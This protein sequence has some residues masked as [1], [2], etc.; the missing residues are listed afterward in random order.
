[1]NII[2]KSIK[3]K[4]P[5]LWFQT[6]TTLWLPLSNKL[7]FSVINRKTQCVHIIK[8]VFTFSLSTKDITNIIKLGTTLAISLR[9]FF[10]YYFCFVPIILL[11]IDK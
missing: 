10:P 9:R 8:D 6:F 3:I 1:M 4:L 11:I 2:G 7:I 5:W